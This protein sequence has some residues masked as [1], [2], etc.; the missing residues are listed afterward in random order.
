MRDY[1]DFRM[2][3]SPDGMSVASDIPRFQCVG[4]MRAA[5]ESMIDHRTLAR[6]I[7][8]LDW[9]QSGSR[10]L[11]WYFRGTSLEVPGRAAMQCDHHDMGAVN[12]E[13]TGI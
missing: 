3:G 10:R 12:F 1:A 2:R 8:C 7:G 5:T 6:A 13:P 9:T 4:I 11:P